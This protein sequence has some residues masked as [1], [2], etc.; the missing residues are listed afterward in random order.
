MPLPLIGVI[1]SILNP[2]R[3]IIDDVTTTDEE[4]L[5]KKAILLKIETELTGK[6]LE[7]ET[8]LA[9]EQA[10]TIRAEA[11]SQ[12]WIARNWRPITMLTFVYIIAHNH[13]IAPIFGVVSLEI[14]PDMWSLIKIGLGGYIVGRSAEKIV[15]ASLNAMRKKEEV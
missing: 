1:S 13:I 6:V 4:R 9:T 14:V 10:K 2:I 11:G 15:P 5:E 8:A 12:S 3:G 7:Y